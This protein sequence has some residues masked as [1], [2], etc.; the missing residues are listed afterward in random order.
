MEIP[1]PNSEQDDRFF[2]QEMRDLTERLRPNSQ[3]GQYIL[4]ERVG[5]GG[6]G[7]V[8]RAE[9]TAS[10]DLVAIKALV[11]PKQRRQVDTLARFRVQAALLAG[12]KHDSVVAIRDIGRHADICYLVMDLVLGPEEHA[13]SLQD[14]A[15]WFEGT[16]DPREVLELFDLLLDAFAHFHAHKIVHGNLK[17]HNVLL[18][19]ASRTEET[20]EAKIVLSDFGLS[21]IMGTDFVV[22]SVRKT[23]KA[24]DARS[25]TVTRRA[26]PPDAK[27]ILQSYDY[28]SPEQRKGQ[29]SSRRS[30]VFSLGLM[31]LHL[32]TGKKVI[33]FQAPSKICPGIDSAWDAFILRATAQD[34]SRRFRNIVEMHKALKQLRCS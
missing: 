22:E 11:P 3:L 29:G 18:K 2:L 5:V 17:P 16:I 25:A 12:L 8:Y 20:W 31:F 6:M 21:R 19:C 4:R 7:A 32:L 15:S 14:Y 33:G 28:M 1:L 9:D 13:V 27:A 34:R 23:V 24:Q 10:G 30:D 26:L